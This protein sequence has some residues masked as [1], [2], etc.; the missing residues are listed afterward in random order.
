MRRIAILLLACFLAGCSKPS[1]PSAKTEEKK[2]PVVSQA[3]PKLKVRLETSK[4]PFVVEVYR[5]WAPR[6]ADRFHELVQAK[7]FDDSRFFRV[8]KGFVAQFGLSGDPEKNQ[9]WS[10]LQILDDPRKEKNARGTLSFAKR[11]ANTRTTQ[12]FINL[13]NNPKLDADGFAPI[14]KVVEGMEVVDKLYSGYGEAIP[15]GAGPDQNKII[16]MGNEYLERNFPQLDKIQR[17]VV[18]E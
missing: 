3:P 6:G 14:G 5:D 9:L 18:I 1:E 16:G 11:R 4:G 15:I 10:Q 13:R 17:V 12:V 2:T 7:F 8:L